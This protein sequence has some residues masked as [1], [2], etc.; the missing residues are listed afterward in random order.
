M[1]R[2]KVR[3][4]G[5]LGA[6]FGRVFEFALETNTVAEAVAALSCQLPGFKAYMM[7]SESRGIGYAVFAGKR[8][9][10]ADEISERSGA[11][12]I[13][14][15]PVLLGS[16]NGGLFQI[17]LG[18][19]LIIAGSYLTVFSGPVGAAMVS[20]GWGMV[21]GGVVQLLSPKPKTAKTTDSPNNQPSY[22]FN[23]AVNTQAQGNPVP[24]GY[25][26][27]IVGSAVISAGIEAED[28]AQFSSTV[29]SGTLAGQKRKSFYD[30]QA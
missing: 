20:L 6:T 2:R 15:A 14:I 5:R 27:M 26:R 3:L 23:G 18:A 29:K 25:G 21:F 9:L 4:Y 1:Q 30:P 16:K 22:V 8:N 17:V 10:A 24:L 7:G 12:D 13:R 28:Y 11:D 19:V